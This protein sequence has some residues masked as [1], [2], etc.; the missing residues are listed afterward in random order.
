MSGARLASFSAFVCQMLLGDYLFPQKTSHPFVLRG[1]A[2]ESDHAETSHMKDADPAPKRSL[3]A[4]RHA[5]QIVAKVQEHP[6]V[7]VSGRTGCGK[8]TKVRRCMLTL[9]NPR[10]LLLELSA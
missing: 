4:E 1:L 2:L 9:S 3:P 6:V 5:A 7:F 10:S 8:S